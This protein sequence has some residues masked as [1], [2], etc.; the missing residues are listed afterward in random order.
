MK[1]LKRHAVGALT[2]A[3]SVLLGAGGAG[4]LAGCESGRASRAQLQP[5]EFRIMPSHKSVL[6]GETVTVTTRTANLVGRDA[7]IKWTATGGELET[8]QNGRVARVRFD[9]PGTYTISARLNVDG[10]MVET[11]SVTVTVHPLNR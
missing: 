9:R 3:A 5:I 8:E 7:N 1:T 6:E 2:I 11:D 4:P 10:E